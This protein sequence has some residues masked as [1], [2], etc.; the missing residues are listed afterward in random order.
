MAFVVGWV[1]F[2]LQNCARAPISLGTDMDDIFVETLPI[3]KRKE[4]F[5]DKEEKEKL[6]KMLNVIYEDPYI[7]GIGSHLQI[8]AT[9]KEN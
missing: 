1:K 2:Y 5:E 3:E 9:K 6:I 4:I 8:V 7:A